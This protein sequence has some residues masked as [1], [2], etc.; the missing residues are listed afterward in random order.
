MCDCECN[1]HVSKKINWIV[2]VKVLVVSLMLLLIGITFIVLENTF[3]QYVDEN[4]VLHESLFLPLGT[5]SVLI[6]GIGLVFVLAKSFMRMRR[7]QP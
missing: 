4:G 7:K 5:I 2:V 1:S 6:A 3:Y